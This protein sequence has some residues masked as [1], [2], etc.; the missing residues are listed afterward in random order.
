EDFLWFT[1][2]HEAAHILKH[3]K[4]DVFIEAPEGTADAATKKKE[5]EANA[6]AADFLI[7]REAHRELIRL[8]PFTSAKIGRFAD[9]L[10]I[11]PGIVVGRLQ[12]DKLIPF[13]QH[14]G[15]KRRFQF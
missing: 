7:P 15:L 13:K 1:F 12:H 4:K 6:F 5:E 9:R 11:A 3:G 10:G 8:K 2:F 14:N